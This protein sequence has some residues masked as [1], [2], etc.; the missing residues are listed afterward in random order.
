[1]YL[2]PSL[3]G[4]CTLSSSMMKNLKLKLIHAN[5]VHTIDRTYSIHTPKLSSVLEDNGG[6]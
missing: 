4:T 5:T 6:V 1:M 2:R 3:I